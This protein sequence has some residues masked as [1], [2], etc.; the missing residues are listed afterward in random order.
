MNSLGSTFYPETNETVLAV[1]VPPATSI[2]TLDNLAHCFDSGGV[3]LSFLGDRDGVNF[4]LISGRDRETYSAA[5]VALK[6]I[7]GSKWVPFGVS[8]EQG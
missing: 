4:A 3:R 7:E 6:H 1:S 8:Y 5:A 2:H